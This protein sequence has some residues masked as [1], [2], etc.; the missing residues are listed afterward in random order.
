MNKKIFLMSLLIAALLTLTGCN[1]Q[2]IDLVYEY[3]Y[4]YIL[5]PNG[6]VVEGKVESWCDYSDGDQVQVKINGDTY[7]TDTTRCVLVKK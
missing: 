6:E 7:L 2:A 5:L 1:Y 4:A 3:N